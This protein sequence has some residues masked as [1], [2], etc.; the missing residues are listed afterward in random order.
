MAQIAVAPLKDHAEHIHALTKWWLAQWGYG[1]GFT[2]TTGRKAVENLARNHASQ[3]ALIGLVDDQPAGSVFLV[4]S[5][6]E[7]HTHLTPWLA[8]LLVQP[9]YRKLGLG[10]CLIRTLLDHAREQSFEEIYLYTAIPS[11]YRRLGWEDFEAIE[12]GGKPN[13]IMRYE[14][15]SHDEDETGR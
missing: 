12:M 2:D 13:M 9:Q 4:E 5:D 7:T 8:G 15:A 14:L 10:E 3:T 6:L 11:L 1:M